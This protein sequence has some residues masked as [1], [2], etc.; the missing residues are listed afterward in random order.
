M[1]PDPSLIKGLTQWGYKALFIS[2]AP[3]YT[4][5]HYSTEYR[6]L[7]DSQDGRPLRP[8]R[9]IVGVYT[10]IVLIWVQIHYEIQAYKHRIVE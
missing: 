1:G 8:G 7:T 5:S 2:P 6:P 3:Q 4:G 9:K 10:Q